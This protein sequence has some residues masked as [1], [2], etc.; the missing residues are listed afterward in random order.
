MISLSI[1]IEIDNIFYFYVIFKSLSLQDDME[2]EMSFIPT[3][4]ISPVDYPD[5]DPQEQKQSL[6]TRIQRHA[7]FLQ[8]CREVKVLHSKILKKS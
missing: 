7:K 6:K 2:T 1:W 8:K 5:L 4:E 3:D